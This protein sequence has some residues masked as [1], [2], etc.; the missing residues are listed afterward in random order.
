MDTALVVTWRTPFPGREQQALDYGVEVQQHWGKLA[1][2][3]ACTAP[4][5]YFLPDGSGMWIVK[6]EQARLEALFNAPVTQLLNTK[7]MLLLADYR[8]SFGVTG[9]GADAFMLRYATAAQELGVL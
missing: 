8:W 2:D 3:G 6:G 1:A 4:E 9:S 5:L 7:G